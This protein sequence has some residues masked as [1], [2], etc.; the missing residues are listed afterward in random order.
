MTNMLPKTI[1]TISPGP[2]PFPFVVVG[3]GVVGGGVVGVGSV[4]DD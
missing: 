2:G 1:A 3:G 4:P